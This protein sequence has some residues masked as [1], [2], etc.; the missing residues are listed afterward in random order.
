MEKI[1]LLVV[2]IALGIGWTLTLYGSIRVIQRFS[3]LCSQ[4]M[5]D[6]VKEW[7]LVAKTIRILLENPVEQEQPHPVPQEG[8]E[9]GLEKAMSPSRAALYKR[10]RGNL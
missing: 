3:S 2:A 6:F 8:T 9:D 10:Q 5:N 7:N 1:S 4:T